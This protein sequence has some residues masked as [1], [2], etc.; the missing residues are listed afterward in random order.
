MNHSAKQQTFEVKWHVPAGWTIREAVTK[1]VVAGGAE[2][3]AVLK[4]NKLAPKE[5]G[6]L[7]ADV[8]FAGFALLSWTEGLLIN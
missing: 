3:K 5:M 1:V 8:S 4:L 2:G 6:V 7:T